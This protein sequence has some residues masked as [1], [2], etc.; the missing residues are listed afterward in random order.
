MYGFIRCAACVPA[1]KVGNVSWNLNKLLTHAEAAAKQGSAVVLFPELSLTSA[2]CGDLFRDRILL[3]Q[4]EKAVAEFAEK[5]AE[6]ST[7]FVLGAPVEE[8]NRIYDCSILVQ[9]GM[10]CGI[11]PKSCRSANAVFAAGNGVEGRDIFYAGM[12][13]PFGTELLFESENGVR[14]GLEI[15]DDA[16]CLIAPGA[17]LALSGANLILNPAADIEFADQARKRLQRLAVQSRQS[18]TGRIYASAGVSESTTDGV[19][20]GHCA[21]FS[22]GKELLNSPRFERDDMLYFFDVDME[23]IDTARLS[24]RQYLAH[25]EMFAQEHFRKVELNLLPESDGELSPVERT[26]FIPADETERAERC[27]EIFEIQTAGLAK[28]MEHTGAKKLVLGIS[29]GLDSTLA[30]LVCNNVMKKLNFPASD[31]IAVTM[32][33]FGTTDRTYDNAVGLCK[34]LGTELREINISKACLQ[35]F[36]DIGHDPENRNVV[37]EN[38]QARERTQIL[39]DIANGVGGL[40][41]GTGDLSEAAMGWCTFNGDH[42]AMYSV[43]CDVPKTLIRPIISRASRNMPE[44]IRNILQDIMET[45]VSPEL[46]P[47]SSG[48]EIKQ[49]TED[50]IGPYEMHDFFLYHFIKYHTSPDKLLFLAGKAFGADYPEE[51]IRKFL[52]LFF[53]RFFSQQFKRSCCQDGPKVGSIALSPRTDWKMPSDASAEEWLAELEK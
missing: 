28:R 4:A 25:S 6:F 33:G 20:S 30:L 23:Q 52:G 36:E 42:I 32:P 39:H 14:I 21:A 27:D 24:D 38:T 22:L 47:A 53:R 34:G 26:P 9:N 40:C 17:A 31:I 7:L 29:G 10:I 48:G 3:K 44:N 19:C 15:G 16:E 37:Y 35:H 43:N 12:T 8:K 49:K 5:T 18:F 13:V 2:S 1:G 46:L 41:I 11:V 45:P 51:N 50:I